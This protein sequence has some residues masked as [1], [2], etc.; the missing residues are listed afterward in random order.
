VARP[1]AAA[2]EGTGSLPAVMTSLFP[3][4][5]WLPAGWYRESTSATS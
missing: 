1:P 5:H 4:H 2:G 3:R